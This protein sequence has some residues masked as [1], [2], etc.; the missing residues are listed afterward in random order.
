MESKGF[1]IVELLVAIV[2]IGVLASITAI[3]YTNVTNRAIIAS[4][5]A[6]L[7]NSSKQLKLFYAID[8]A[9]PTANN[10]PSPSSEEICLKSST[11]TS[12]Q[13]MAWNNLNPA[14]F[15]LTAT[16]NNII[17]STNNLISITAGGINLLGGNTALEKTSTN[18][19]LK[20]DDTAP[21]FDTYG[22][23]QYTISFDIKSADISARSTMQVYMQNGSGA[24]YNFY[25]T[26]PVTT[27]FT[28]QSV[29]ITPSLS[30]VNLTLSMLAFYGIYSTGNIPSVKNVKIEFGAVATDWSLAP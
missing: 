18:E 6:D 7:T 25:A 26:V 23:R 28:R 24:R 21:I 16:K 13:Y 2:I 10:C 27:S 15:Y 4:I 8:E 12:Y 11:G 29:T 19:F 1:T 22:L 14:S 17:Y 30:N 9:Y 20:Y 3:S 5:Q